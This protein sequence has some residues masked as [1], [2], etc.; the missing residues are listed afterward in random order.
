MKVGTEWFVD[1]EG[2]D[3]ALLRDLEILSAVCDRIIRDLDLRVVGD[4]HWHKFGLE[5]GVTGLYLLTESHLTLHTYPEYGIATFNLYC[6]RS[7]AE[8]GWEEQLISCLGA[9]RVRVSVTARG[10]GNSQ[11]TAAVT[12]QGGLDGA[13]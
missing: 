8:W 13:S 10:T 3:P 4:S 5:G 12:T 7:R 9:E 6:C 2:C 1:A 11:M